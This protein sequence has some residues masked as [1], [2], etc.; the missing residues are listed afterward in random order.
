MLLLLKYPK[1][2]KYLRLLQ[3]IKEKYYNIVQ[4]LKTKI[5]KDSVIVLSGNIFSASLGFLATILIT[6]TLGPVQFGLFS[7]ALAVM[8]IASQFSDFGI[9]TGLVR[10]ASLYLKN[11]DQKANLIFKVSLKFKLIITTLVI[12]TGLFIS[13]FLAIHIFG[14]PDLIF[15]LKLAFIGAFGLSLIGYISTTL[16]ARQS[17]KKF[18]LVNLITPLGKFTLIGLLFLTYKLNL[19]S[20]ITTIA[21]LPFIAFLV[22]SLIIPRDF[23]RAKGD[24]NEAFRGLFRFSKWILVSLLCVMIFNRLD[25]LMLVYFKTVEVVGY[26]SAAY[27]FAFVF[28]LITG[29]ITTI[30]LPKVSGLSKKEQLHKYIRKSLKFT[31]PIIFP[32]FILLLISRPIILSIYGSEYLPSVIIFQILICGFTLSIIINPIGLII[33]SLNK[34]EILAYLNIIQLILNFLGNL[35]LIPPHGAVGAAIS[36]LF[37]RIVGTIF[38][39]SYVYFNLLKRY[40]G[41]II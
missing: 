27:K 8:G 30:L 23:L 29:S 16:Q 40:N 17:F 21:I 5:V 22:G 38:I 25:I 36:T 31:M 6:R 14:N 41:K 18:T 34:P 33:Y 24:E 11:D 13:K 26:Y 4:L 28:P 35:F 9:G 2:R 3:E 19:F 7:V 10:F 37:V 39:G 1:R 32:L 12:L 15:P 20:A